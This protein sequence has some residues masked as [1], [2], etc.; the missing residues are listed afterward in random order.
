MTKAYRV[1]F[2]KVGD[3]EV[4]QESDR[5]TGAGLGTISASTIVWAVA[6]IRA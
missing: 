6:V 2:S 1:Y 4:E 3:V 5:E